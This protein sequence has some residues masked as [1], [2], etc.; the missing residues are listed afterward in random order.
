MYP[1][2]IPF[3]VYYIWSIFCEIKMMYLGRYQNTNGRKFQH[4]YGAVH[5]IKINLDIYCKVQPLCT[6]YRF[7]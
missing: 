2:Y 4:L 1:I 6:S 5:L 3:Y 7:F